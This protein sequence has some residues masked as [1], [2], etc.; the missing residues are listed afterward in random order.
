MSRVLK[1][2][3]VGEKL[4]AELAGLVPVVARDPRGGRPRLDDRQVFNGI[5]FVLLTGIPWEDLPQAMGFGSGMTCWRR[6]Q[7]WQRAG[8]WE[9]LH[10]TLLG[11]LR[12]VDQITWERASVDSA[13]VAAP[14]GAR[15][16]ART[17]RI[18]PNSAASVT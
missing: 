4:W 12:E 13:S 3:L 17:P 9:A 1:R 15:R 7:A 8:V 5:L 6:L 10:R 2:E 14:R 11:R 16:S 18:A